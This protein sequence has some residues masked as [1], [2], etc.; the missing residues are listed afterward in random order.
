MPYGKKLILHCSQG[1]PANL[2]QMVADFVRDRVTFVAVCGK[3]CARTE[4]TIDEICVGDGR[5]PYSLLTSSHPNESLDDVKRF[6]LSLEL[7]YA[8]E[9]EVVEC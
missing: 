4:D 1:V 6:A 2:N 3:D 7:E 8:G 5:N 9:I